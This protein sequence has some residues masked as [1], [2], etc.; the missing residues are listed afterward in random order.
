[1]AY[2]SQSD[3]EARFG[4][5]EVADLLDLN[6]DSSA[7]SGRLASAQSDADALI[8]G[9]ISGR[10]DTPLSTVP[11]VI[12]NI[13]CNLVRFTLSANNVPE[14]VQ[15]RYDESIRILKDIAAGKFNLPVDEVSSSE[16]TGGI[17]YNTNRTRLFESND[18]TDTFDGY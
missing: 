18:D 12:V 14:E 7:D 4:V 9:Y 3:L 11:N 15:K 2:C 10:Y 8:D 6:N 5:Q 13:A 16:S 1:M 17:V